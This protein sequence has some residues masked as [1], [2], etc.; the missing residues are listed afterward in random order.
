MSFFCELFVVYYVLGQSM[1]K[2]MK[3]QQHI[4]RGKG[5]AIGGVFSFW[6]EGGG[7]HAND[8]L[9]LPQVRIQSQHGMHGGNGVLRQYELQ[10]LQPHPYTVG[11][12]AGASPA[13][14]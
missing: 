4:D 3:I 14:S 2:S 7:H 5:I 8:T 11:H 1:P 13:L 9:Q 12:A 10:D 6:L